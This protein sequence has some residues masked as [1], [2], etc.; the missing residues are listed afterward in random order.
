MICEQWIAKDKKVGGRGLINV[1]FRNLFLVNE[2]NKETFFGVTYVPAEI[3]YEAD[4][5]RMQV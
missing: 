3:T 4:A 2:E 5:T 1:I